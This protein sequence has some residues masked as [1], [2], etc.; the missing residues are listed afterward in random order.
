MSS[1]EDVTGH[2][3]VTASRLVNR[4]SH[5]A[6]GLGPSRKA[7]H[8]VVVELPSPKGTA[9]ARRRRISSECSIKKD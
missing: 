1:S 5:V 8:V 6:R 9:A 7:P 2:S 4:T 3:I